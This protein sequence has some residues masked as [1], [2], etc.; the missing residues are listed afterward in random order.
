[1]KANENYTKNEKLE[2]VRETL[3]YS[4][5][6]DKSKYYRI[7]NWVTSACGNCKFDNSKLKL[8]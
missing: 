6:T 4:S 5:K 1:M 7:E 8:Q 2:M 3:Y